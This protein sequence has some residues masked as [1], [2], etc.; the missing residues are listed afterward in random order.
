MPLRKSTVFLYYLGATLGVLAFISAQAAVQR[1]SDLPFVLERRVMVERYGLTD[2]C[3]FTD[4]RYTRNPALADLST[5]FQD[6]PLSMEHFP[7]ASIV[8]PPTSI[9]RGPDSTKAGVTW[10]KGREP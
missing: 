4:A 9:G 7:S 6:H 1:K 5:P 10:T 3:M 2:L 8:A